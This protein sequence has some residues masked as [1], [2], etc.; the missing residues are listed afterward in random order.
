M[1]MNS[2]KNNDIKIHTDQGGLIFT[3]LLNGVLFYYVNRLNE[4]KDCECAKDWRKDYLYYYTMAVIGVSV[5]L[6]IGNGKI[7]QNVL[8]PI[9]MLRLVGGLLAFYC[10]FTYMRELR[11]NCPCAIEDKKNKNLNEFFN[12]YTGFVIVLML[13]SVAIVLSMLFQKK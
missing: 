6:L 13:I 9:A 5:V 4:L 11:D 2:K 10:I 3:I 12:I 8:M 1:K 7:S